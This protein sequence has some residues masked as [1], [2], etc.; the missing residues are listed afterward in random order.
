MDHVSA[1]LRLGG[2][3]ST[4]AD[5]TWRAMPLESVAE[6]TRIH[7]AK[8]ARGGAETRRL[9]DHVSGARRHGGRISTQADVTQYAGSREP[10]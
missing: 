8:N 1:Y 3:I 2:R 9:V 7:E 4:Q 6:R 10:A 5:V